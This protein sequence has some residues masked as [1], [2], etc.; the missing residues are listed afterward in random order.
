MRSAR[1]Q[2]RHDVGVLARGVLDSEFAALR[3]A[4]PVAAALEGPMSAACPA[5]W[6]RTKK[7]ATLHLDA[8]SAGKLTIAVS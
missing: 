3:K 6:L 1:A 7:G 5:S 4:A 2:N 8:G